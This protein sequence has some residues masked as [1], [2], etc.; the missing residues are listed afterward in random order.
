MAAKK[1]KV[2]E[3][4]EIIVIS[5]G[6]AIGLYVFAIKPYV[7]PWVQEKL[8]IGLVAAVPAKTEMMLQSLK[9]RESAPVSAERQAIEALRLK[10]LKV[11]NLLDDANQIFG[12]VASLVGIIIGLKTLLRNVKAKKVAV[13]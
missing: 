2:I 11:K 9:S 7:V 5:V 4:W 6:L 13:K 10:H 1:K 8:N 3:V 12:I